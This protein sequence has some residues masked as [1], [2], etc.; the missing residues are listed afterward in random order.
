MKDVRV[1][2]RL[3]T[4]EDL[5]DYGIYEGKKRLMDNRQRRNGDWFWYS[6]SAA[7]RAAK[8]TAERIGIPYSDELI[9]VRG[10]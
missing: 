3:H 7:I 4:C 10:C 2:V 8:A 5:Y 1:K 6:E 9:K